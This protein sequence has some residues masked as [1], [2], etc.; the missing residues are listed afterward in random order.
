MPSENLY[1]GR[2]ASAMH[3]RDVSG[4]KGG[5]SACSKGQSYS[6]EQSAVRFGDIPFSHVLIDF[7]KQTLMHKNFTLELKFRTFYPN[8]LLFI[9][10]VS[11]RLFY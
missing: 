5:V 4:S 1:G 6:L 10:L 8:G 2:V 9:I 7:Q 11:F 3:T